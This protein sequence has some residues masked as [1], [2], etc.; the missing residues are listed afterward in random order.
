VTIAGRFDLSGGGLVG[1][2]VGCNYQVAPQWVIGFE[3]DFSAIDKKGE[4]RDLA[5]LFNV[6]FEQ[7]TKERWFAT[8]R[9]WCRM[10]VLLLAEHVC[11]V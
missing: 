2:T 8:R 1:G 5:P 10:E 9:R 6:N 4:A 11:E 7:E 3:G